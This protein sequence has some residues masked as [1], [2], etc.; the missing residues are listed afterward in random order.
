MPRNEC[1]PLEILSPHAGHF[2]PGI[3]AFLMTFIIGVKS[4]IRVNVTLNKHI[5]HMLRILMYLN[6]ALL[7]K[8]TIA[9]VILNNACSFVGIKRSFTYHICKFVVL[10]LPDEEEHPYENLKCNGTNCANTL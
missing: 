9:L 8:S 10:P 1:L 2:F 4:Y 6:C 5:E 3:D 7:F